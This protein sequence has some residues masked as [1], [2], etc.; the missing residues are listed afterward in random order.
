MPIGVVRV[1]GN[2]LF[3]K[4]FLSFLSAELKKTTKPVV[5]VVSAIPEIQKLILEGLKGLLARTIDHATIISEIEKSLSDAGADFVENKVA[6]QEIASLSSLLNGIQLTGDYSEALRDSVLS[7]SEKITVNA[8]SGWIEA[9][10]LNNQVL[11]PDAFNFQV[12]EE[13]GNASVLKQNDLLT[14]KALLHAITLIPGSYGFT[15]TGKLAR[16]GVQAADYSAA[17][18]TRIVK[19]DYLEIW[20]PGHL[21]RSGDPEIVQNSQVLARLTYEEA[22]ELSYFSQSSLHPRLVEPLIEKHIQVHIYRLSSSGKNLETV[23]NT[24]SVIASRVVKSVVYDD[25]VAILKLNGAGVGFKPGIL[26]KVTSA[27]HLAGIN[28]R[29]VITSQVSINIILDKQDSARV[30][31]ICSDIQLSSVNEIHIHDQVSLIAVVGHGML[32][33]HGVSSRLFQAVASEKINVLLSGSGASD[34][35]SYLVIDR[36]E[37]EKAVRKIHQVFLEE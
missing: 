7:F 36:Q 24:E 25:Q 5:L 3:N 6:R 22:S 16:L 2:S 14:E 15:E 35:V 23:I 17:A 26:A 13:F 9:Q 21:F 33:Q 28:I 11:Y 1:G 34:L 10:G 32:S 19:A 12:T 27:F 18:I 4:E 29:S 8:L 30:R 20:K 31:K 37:K